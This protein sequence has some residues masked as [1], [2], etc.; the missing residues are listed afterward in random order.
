MGLDVPEYHFDDGVAPP[1]FIVKIFTGA[2]VPMPTLPVASIRILST[3]LVKILSGIELV[4][5]N[6]EVAVAVLLPAKLQYGAVF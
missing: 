1:V 2:V 5:P 6:F 3:L 4:V